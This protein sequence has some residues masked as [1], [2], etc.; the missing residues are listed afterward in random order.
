MA[1]GSKVPQHNTVHHTS[2][3]ARFSAMWLLSFPK[4]QDSIKG[5]KI[6]WYHHDPSKV[7]GHTS[8]VSNK[9]LHKV[10]QIVVQ[11]LGLLV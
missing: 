6:E 7:A 5:K 9:T 1:A 8:Q 10:L 11:S 4:T 3:F 2:L